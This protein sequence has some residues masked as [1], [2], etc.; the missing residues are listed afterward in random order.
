MVNELNQEFERRDNIMISKKMETALNKQINAEFYSS[1]LYLSM[2]ADFEAKNLPGFANWMKVQAQEEWGHGMRIYQ[3][4][5]EQQGRVTLEAIE[6]P[7][8]EWASALEMFE[9]ANKHEQHVTSLIH[10]LVTV[11]TGEKDYASQI[12]LQWFVNEQVEEEAS[13]SAIVA[14]LKMIGDSPQGLLILDHELGER[15]A[16]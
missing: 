9:A 8:K 13:A 3:Y 11:A 12:F 1:Y 10:D 2:A 7:Q 6:A 4:I 16:H 5:N 14:R 15:K